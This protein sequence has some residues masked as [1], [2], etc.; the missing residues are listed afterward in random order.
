MKEKSTIALVDD[1]R[2]ILTSL[3]TALEAE[4]FKVR[5]YSDGKSALE[6]LTEEPADLGVFGI[7]GGAVPS[8]HQPVRIGPAS[9][10]S[11]AGDAVVPAARRPSE[12]V[13]DSV[14]CS[15]NYRY[16]ATLFGYR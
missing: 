7:V 11:S 5:T 9:S 15:A 6:A 8:P 16:G 12:R 13:A 10:H 2:N 4:G 1:E 3:R 14:D